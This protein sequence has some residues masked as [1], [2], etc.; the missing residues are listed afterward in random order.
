MSLSKPQPPK[1]AFHFR[2]TGPLSEILELCTT[3]WAAG[4][5]SRKLK[6]G[7]KDLSCFHNIWMRTTVGPELCLNGNFILK[8]QASQSELSRKGQRF[9]S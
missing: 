8:P 5:R 1:L 9:S 7:R 2:A 4:R 6:T 3:S